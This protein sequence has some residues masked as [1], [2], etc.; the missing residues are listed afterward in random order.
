MGRFDLW[1]DSYNCAL[2]TYNPTNG[3]Q[4]PTRRGIVQDATTK[5]QVKL[6]AATAELTFVGITIDQSTKAG[7]V[8]A[9]KLGMAEI[10]SDG[11][12]VINP[13][14]W[15]VLVG[16]A[17]IALAGRCKAQAIAAGS[18]NVYN[19]IGRCVNKNQVAATAGLVVEC[20]IGAF[21]VCAA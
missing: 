4:I 12:A 13:G 14:D 6:P 17:S 18:A 1:S 16:N 10:E 20:E 8:R 9:Q 7:N 15:L 21:I 2:A 3:T 11:S 19:I 5:G